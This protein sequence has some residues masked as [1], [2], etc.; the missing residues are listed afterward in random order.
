MILL[1]RGLPGPADYGTSGDLIWKKKYAIK[2]RATCYFDEE[3]TVKPNF[4]CNQR[5]HMINPNTYN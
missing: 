5:L 4:E 3:G 1:G 2:G